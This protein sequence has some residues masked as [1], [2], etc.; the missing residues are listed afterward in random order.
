M[1]LGMNEGCWDSIGS[2]DDYLMAHSSGVVALAQRFFGQYYLRTRHYHTSPR[3]TP[4]SK[5]DQIQICSSDNDFP[6]LMF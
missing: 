5:C 2:K 4:V 3:L 1:S 6:Y